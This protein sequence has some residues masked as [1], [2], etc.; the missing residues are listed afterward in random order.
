MIISFH[1]LYVFK[2]K[3]NQYLI[4]LGGAGVSSDFAIGS[5]DSFKT[6]MQEHENPS[7]RKRNLNMGIRLKRQNNF[8]TGNAPENVSTNETIDQIKKLFAKAIEATKE[9]IAKV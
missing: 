7:R 2:I 1:L 8:G 3:I 9:M 4:I 5:G 6:A